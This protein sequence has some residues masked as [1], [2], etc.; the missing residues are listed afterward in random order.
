MSSKTGK[1]ETKPNRIWA[2]AVVFLLVITVAAIII[3]LLGYRPANAIEIHLHE[4]SPTTG[5]IQV[6]GEVVNPGIYPFSGSDTVQSIINAAGGTKENE[7]NSVFTLNIGSSGSQNY[8]QKINI[9]RADAWLLQALP[10]I[11][12]TKAKTIVAYRSANG[13]FK[14]TTELMNVN[15]IG[16]PLFHQIKDLITVTD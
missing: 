6:S 7:D 5:S 13:P 2:I 9:N 10:G 4:S 14:T 3:A 12:E 1:P 16:E 11:G 15:G 8:A